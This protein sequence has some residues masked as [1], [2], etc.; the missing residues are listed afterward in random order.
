MFDPLR[1]DH[2]RSSLCPNRDMCEPVG[3]VSA[4]AAVLI[5]RPGAGFQRARCCRGCAGARG[6]LPKVSLGRAWLRIIRKA[7]TQRCG[8][9]VAGYGLAM[10]P[11]AGDGC[12]ALPSVLHTAP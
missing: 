8:G 1:T 11:P 9:G 2:T 3:A 7:V 12:W 10:A 4:P 5:S 6:G